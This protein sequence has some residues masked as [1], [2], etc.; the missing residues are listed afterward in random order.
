MR[1]RWR[2]NRM[3]W[4]K[5]LLSMLVVFEAA[6]GVLASP[7][8][9]GANPLGTHYLGEIRL[10]PYQNGPEGWVYCAGQDL[11]LSAETSA[12]FSLIGDQFGGEGGKT[13]AL[14]DLRGEEPVPGMGYYIAVEGIYPR[15]ASLSHGTMLGEVRLFPYG[16]W[17]N[18]NWVLADGDYMSDSEPLYEVYGTAFGGWPG[19]FQLPKIAPVQPHIEYYIARAGEKAS[20]ANAVYAG[21]TRIFPPVD[22]PALSSY[23]ADGKLLDIAAN[24][25]LYELI[26]SR[27]GGTPAQTFALPDLSGNLSLQYYVFHDGYVPALQQ[28]QPVGVPDHYTTAISTPLSVS[29]GGVMDND[30]NVLTAKLV[31]EPAHGQVTLSKKGGFTY[32]PDLDYEG[33][34]SFAYIASNNNKSTDITLVTINVAEP[35]PKI[36]GVTD[37]GIYNHPVTPVY[38]HG[39]GTLDGQPFASGTTISMDGRYQ[40]VVE[41]PRGKKATANFE[42]DQT[43]PVVTGVTDGERY[44]Q[45]RQIFFNEGNATLNQQVFRSGDKVSTEGQY[46]LIVTDRAG[47]MTRI[48]FSIYYPKTITFNSNGGSPVADMVVSYDTTASKPQDPLKTGFVF[49]GWY[50]DQAL[51]QPYDFALPIQTDLTLYAK[52]ID[53]DAPIVV[54]QAPADSTEGVSIGTTLSFEFNEPVIGNHGKNISVIRAADHQIIESI[55]V[56]DRAHVSVIDKRVT[57]R[58]SQNLSY[59]TRYEIE[60]EDG[61]FQDEAGNPYGGMQGVGGWS[62]TTEAEPAAIPAAPASLTAMAGD[63]KVSLQWSTVTGATYYDVYAGTESGIYGGAPVVTVPDTAYV[64]QSLR[65]GTTYF[66]AVKAGNDGGSSTFSEEVS[67]V[68]SGASIPAPGD[69]NL[70]GLSLSHGTLE[71]SFHSDITSYTSR[72]GNSITEISVTPIVSDPLA[73]VTL[74]GQVVPMDRPSDPIGLVV[75]NNS[76]TLVVTAPDGTTKTYVVDVTREAAASPEP[77]PEPEPEPEPKPEP[78]PEQSANPDGGNTSGGGS[79]SSEGAGATGGDVSQARP[80]ANEGQAAIE[81]GHVTSYLNDKLLTDVLL[82]ALTN[83]NG[84]TVLTIKL[85]GDKLQS[86]LAEGKNTRPVIRLHSTDDLDQAVVVLDS[87]S[88][89]AL[90]GNSGIIE[91]DTLA[92]SIRIPLKAISEQIGSFAGTNEGSIHLVLTRGEAALGAKVKQLGNDKHLR[93]I[94]GSMEVNVV[95]YDQEKQRRGS[96]YSSYV[97]LEIPLTEEAAAKL[98]TTAVLLD[99]KGKI[100]HAPTRLVVRDGMTYARVK[101]LYNGAYA[102]IGYAENDKLSDVKG[103]WAETAVNE[104]ASRLIVS[105]RDASG[106]HPNAPI[107]RA[108]FVTMMVRSLG[109]ME[110]GS[111]TAFHDV[112]SHDWYV[113]AVAAASEYGLVHG[114]ADGSFLPNGLISRQEAMVILA[115]ALRT[116]EVP[117][118]GSLDSDAALASF[119]DHAELAGWA[120]AAAAEMIGN[121]IMSG[122]GGKLNPQSNMTRAETA[123]TLLRM[124]SASGMIED[125]SSK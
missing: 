2:D 54:G 76:V 81:S 73:T 69:A 24:R 4:S 85:N 11:K 53:A 17:I 63:G 20:S 113:G 22:I 3:R 119:Q 10:F 15:G 95:A 66:F 77:K 92:G 122:Y 79:G 116:A 19:S 8:S 68:P 80:G 18:D 87:K 9:V 59:L 88:A 114:Y 13:F 30:E 45:E 104:M 14:P 27:F 75:G 103:H 120:K 12:L 110:Q 61:A 23:K 56:T 60:I 70:I 43:A 101:G 71:P 118:S 32:T 89:K 125:M 94:Y 1:K 90:K 16:M 25:D 91:L 42:I 98:V 84:Q 49:G 106:F 33:T 29:S 67:A 51:S 58:L 64:A 46:E 93:T 47:N 112:T 21:E 100:H 107:T 108:E 48:K 7:K 40:L 39:T 86:L 57:V 121:E 65:N 44:E 5:I 62:F 102:L 78:K 115:R 35:Q 41:S 109:L 96:S 97:E 26:G 38:V 117:L 28:A 52:W 83:E 82:K 123:A 74:N 37:G 124:L 31:G 34:D 111:S 99:D 36:I 50:A 72:V 6:I 105:G 55:D